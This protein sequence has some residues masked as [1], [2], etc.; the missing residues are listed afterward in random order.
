MKAKWKEWKQKFKNLSLKKKLLIFYSVLFVLPLF[1]ISIIIYVEVS[2]SMLE[3]IQYSARQGYE[4]AKSYLEYKIL[5]LVQRT[6]VV[7]TN[8][9]LKNM[10]NPD[11]ALK[12]GLHEQLAQKEVIRSY[13]Q[14]VESSSQNLRLQLYISDEFS[15]LADGDYILSLSEADESLWYQKKGEQKIYFA[16]GI[17]LEERKKDRYV[18]LVRDITEENNY[19]VRNSVL[20]MDIG[21]SELEE[22]LQNATPTENAVSYLINREN[23]VVSASNKEKLK[24]LGLSGQLPEAFCFSRY[25]TDSELNEE[26]LNQKTVY[27]MRNKIRNTDWE[28]ITVIPKADMTSGIARLQSIVAGLMILF[29]LMT[30]SGGAVI[31]SWIVRRISTLNDSFNQVKAGDMGVHLEADTSDEI[32]VLYD[33]YNEMIDHTRQLMDEKY[34]MGV[35]LKSAELKAL[36]SQINPHFL[37]NTLDMVNWLAFAGRTQDIHE[38]VI[39]LSKYYRLILN[40]GQDTLTLA[41][42]L[43]H[44]SYYIKIQDIRFPGRIKYQEQVDIGV[45]GSIV[46]KIILQPLVENAIQHGIWEKKEKTG[47]IQILGYEEA[48][49]VYLKVMDDGVGMDSA[50]LAHV[51]D[52]SLESSGSSYGVKN[53]NARIRLMFGEEYGLSYDS[54]PGEGTCVTV[55]FPRNAQSVILP[56]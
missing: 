52:G 55:R 4:Q 13:L 24:A 28:M 9:D 3:K 12:T 17:Y 23:T 49:I 56:K 45:K 25:V 47:T 43:Q 40:K 38:A 36:Q 20:R 27:C 10:V 35:H 8:N 30:I 32:G 31:I 37:Y 41:E 53:V 5:Q 11:N 44:V 16:P 29:G 50:T 7:V 42:E 21:I 48:G 19:R 39:S 22:I 33:N 51:M 46:P 1:L 34:H 54:A 14:S 6:D 18:A 15:L 26:S 2:Q